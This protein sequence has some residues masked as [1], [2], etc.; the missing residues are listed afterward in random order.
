MSCYGKW[1]CFFEMTLLNNGQD[2][3]SILCCKQEEVGIEEDIMVVT[4]QKKVKQIL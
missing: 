3:V 1:S 4:S 2:F